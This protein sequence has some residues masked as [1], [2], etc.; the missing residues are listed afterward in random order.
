MPTQRAGSSP[1]LSRGWP[2]RGAALLA[3]LVLG[4]SCASDMFAELPERAFEQHSQ[5]TA[6]E[7]ETDT[8]E[9]ILAVLPTNFP[10]VRISQEQ[11]TKALVN[12]VKDMPLPVKE[13]SRPFPAPDRRIVLTSGSATGAAWQTP[14]AQGYGRF[15]ARRGTPGDCLNRFDDGPELDDDDKRA[16]ALALA[17]NPA[18]E[19]ADAE[20]RA[21]ISPTQ[22]AGLW[23]SR[24]HSGGGRRHSRRDGAGQCG[25][26][27]P[28]GVRR[29]DPRCPAP[30]R[31][32]HEQRR[33]PSHGSR[34]STPFQDLSCLQVLQGI[35][36]GHGKRR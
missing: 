24:A 26:S 6:A 13:A 32:G 2:H 4:V 22:P 5:D 31:A 25:E 16:I 14:L 18:L 17:I 3:L 36:A 35:Q 12:L 1:H 28:L 23:A 7:A 21:L 8:E 9:R 30:Q 33:R 34:G 11:F 10:A 27:H 20:L 15:C 29:F 19:A